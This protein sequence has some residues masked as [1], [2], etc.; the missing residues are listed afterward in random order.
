MKLHMMSQ[1]VHLPG[2][3]PAT[4]WSKENHQTHFLALERPITQLVTSTSSLS[5]HITQDRKHIVKAL[6]P[7]IE[8]I[9]KDDEAQ[10]VLFSA[11]DIIEYAAV[12][13]CRS[14]TLTSPTA[15]PS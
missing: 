4:S 1:K 14:R 8:R 15:I 6:K 10:L 5:L 9:C 3:E 13:F 12:G 7:H 2:I 11:L